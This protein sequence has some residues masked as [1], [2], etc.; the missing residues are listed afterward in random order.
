MIEKEGIF[1]NMGVKPKTQKR[2]KKD[3]LH[4]HTNNYFR[5]DFYRFDGEQ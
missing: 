2:R 3:A 4:I 1:G 5:S